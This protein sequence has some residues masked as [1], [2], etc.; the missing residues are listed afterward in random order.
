MC[1]FTIMP[2]NKLV[3]SVCCGKKKEKYQI[4]NWWTDGNA[5]G[6]AGGNVS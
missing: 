5:G 4:I 1:C 2:Y 6:I 3:I